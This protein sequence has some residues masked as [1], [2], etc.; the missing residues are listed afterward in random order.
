MRKDRKLENYKIKLGVFKINRNKK[1]SIR[2]K[3]LYK[4]SI[5]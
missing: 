1:D 4:R 5:D 2:R 3:N